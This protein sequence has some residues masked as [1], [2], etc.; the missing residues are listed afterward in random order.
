MYVGHGDQ[1]RARVDCQEHRQG[2]RLIVGGTCEP[3]GTSKSSL[4][5]SS[6]LA[7][8]T[9]PTGGLESAPFSDDVEVSQSGTST[10]VCCTPVRDTGEGLRCRDS[11]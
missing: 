7:I 10:G 11:P 5:F 6:A 8:A 9:D 2:P 4:A 1:G 3:G